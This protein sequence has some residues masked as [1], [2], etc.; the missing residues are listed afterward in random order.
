MTDQINT[1][2]TFHPIDNIDT[3]RMIKNV[4]L[5]KSKR[6]DGISSEVLNLKS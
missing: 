2:F 1:H 6:H 4:K 5:S 3:K